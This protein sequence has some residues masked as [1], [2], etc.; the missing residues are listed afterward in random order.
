MLSIDFIRKNKDKIQDS[1]KNRKLDENLLDEF[2]IFD[3]LRVDLLEK[4]A[5]INQSRNELSQKLKSERNDKLIE[6][7]RDLKIQKEAL[8][9]E[10]APIEEK[11]NDLLY[12]LPNVFDEAVPEGSG[13]D[14]NVEIYAWT[15]KDKKLPNDSLGT[16]NKSSA[17]M[18][19]YSPHSKNHEF[20]LKD[21]IEL[22]ELHDI[23]DVKQ[24]AKVS[25]SRFSYLKR[26]AV[27]LQWALVNHLSSKLI[28]EGFYPINPPLLVKERALFGTSHF[29][30]EKNQVYSVES[31]QTEENSKLYLVGS[32][33]PSNFSYFMDKVINEEDLPQK[34]FA[35]TVCFRTEVGSWGKDVRGIKRVHQFDKVELAIVSTPS[36][37]S[38]HF[39]ELID[40][41]KWF[42]ESLEIPFHVILKCKADSG[43]LASS[44]QADVEAWIPSQNNFMEVGTAT[45]ATDYQ[46]R[47]L[48][49][50]Y[51]DNADGSLHF[52]HTLNDTGVALGRALIAIM[53][54][55]QQSDGSILIPKVLQDYLGFDIIKKSK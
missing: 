6:K 34:I 2:F 31:S 35:N 43:Y 55:Y 10:L 13:E 8:E 7:G 9:K 36:E 40:I 20:K 32:S 47:R 25:G 24:S 28:K 39:Y 5:H 45:N 22:G 33:E 46:A 51:K 15:P 26:E 4:I 38:K 52:V 53:D 42:W 41:N 49:I 50:K 44:I 27:L 14:D 29:P 21:H 16:H 18:P 19:K 1:I 23:I 11:Y 48:N 54:N 17:L 30:Q 12:W 3:K 37:S